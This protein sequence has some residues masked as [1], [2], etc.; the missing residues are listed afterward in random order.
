MSSRPSGLT[1]LQVAVEQ[2]LGYITYR[3]GAWGR[4]FQGDDGILVTLSGVARELGGTVCFVYWI[5]N[6][7]DPYLLKVIL[8]DKRDGEKTVT[9]EF[10]EVM[11]GLSAW[12]LRSHSA[13]HNGRV[14][15]LGEG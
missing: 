5:P 1:D 12:M 13:I 4:T 10:Q 14:E 15:Y 8:R 6:S 2:I 11:R 3:C 9:H 7:T